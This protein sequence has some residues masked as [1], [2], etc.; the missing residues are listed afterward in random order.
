LAEVFN[1]LGAVSVT[2]IAVNYW[3]LIAQ[4]ARPWMWVNPAI[5]DVVVFTGLLLLCVLLVHVVLRR[6]TELIKWERLHWTIQGLGLILGGMRGLWW[7][8]LV[9]VVLISSGVTYLQESVEV[10]S[11]LGPRLAGIA[12]ENLER[13]ADRFPGAAQRGSGHLVPPLRFSMKGPSERPSKVEP[14]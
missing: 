4:W 10:R 11:V 7:S 14:Q 8:G 9:L 2:V 1:L 12:R 5:A 3:N 6:L 13:I